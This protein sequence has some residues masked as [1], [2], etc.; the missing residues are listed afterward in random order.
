MNGNPRKPNGFTLIELLVVVPIFL[1]VIGGLMSFMI[2]LYGQLLIKNA[3][4]E[5]S[6]QVQTAYSLLQ[7]DLFFAQNFAEKA[8]S[9]M[10]DNY[11]P[12]GTATGWTYKSTPYH[13]LILYQSALD[14]SFNDPNRNLVYQKTAA[15]GNSCTSPS[16]ELNPPVL[17]NIIYYVDSSNKLRRRILVPDPVNPRCSNPHLQ[18]SCPTTTTRVR[19]EAGGGTSTVAC[20]EDA[21]IAEGVSNFDVKYYD[22]ND[23]LLDVYT[24]STPE[25]PAC[26]CYDFESWDYDCWVYCTEEWGGEPCTCEN[27]GTTPAASPLQATRATVTLTLKRQVIGSDF[28]FKQDLTLKRINSGDPNLQ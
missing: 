20:P 10:K 2:S 9:I 17:N 3:Q 16:L 15:S 1:V 13:S 24:T 22:A 27:P 8:H 23:Q 7:N 18:Q 6:V 11:G 26:D 28:T 19:Q 5:M 14:K 4:T 12:G 25:A 21:I